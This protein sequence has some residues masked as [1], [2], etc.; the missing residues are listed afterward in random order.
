MA[1]AEPGRGQQSFGNPKLA[2]K[3]AMAFPGKRAIAGDLPVIDGLLDELKLFAGKEW[4]VEW[5]SQ[6]VDALS[7][8]A[9]VPSFI[10]GPEHNRQLS[11]NGRRANRRRVRIS[12]RRPLQPPISR[13]VHPP[14]FEGIELSGMRVPALIPTSYQKQRPA[15]RK[16]NARPNHSSLS[17]KNSF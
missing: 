2:L 10:S 8:M 14:M 4:S 16:R 1:R 15:C 3:Q 7:Q 17:V 13:A 11:K 12:L 6:G 5:N 9:Q